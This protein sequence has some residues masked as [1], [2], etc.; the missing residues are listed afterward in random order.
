MHQCACIT[1][2]CCNVVFVV[3]NKQIKNALISMYHQGMFGELKRSI[4]VT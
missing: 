3:F 2:V 4:K 1:C